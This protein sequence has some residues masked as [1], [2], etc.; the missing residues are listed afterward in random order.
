MDKCYGFVCNIYISVHVSK[1]THMDM[2]VCVDVDVN[3]FPVSSSILFHMT[4]F[5]FFFQKL[6]LHNG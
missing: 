3:M 5:F 1:E 4:C 2:Q 6:K